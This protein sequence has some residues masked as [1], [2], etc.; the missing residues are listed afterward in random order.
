M[1]AVVPAPCDRGPVGIQGFHRNKCLSAFPWIVDSNVGSE[2]AQGVCI[3]K[4]FL[5]VETM[6]CAGHTIIGI[7]EWP[8]MQSKVVVGMSAVL[9]RQRREAR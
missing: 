8:Q 5:S 1:M 4:G 6:K 3:R 7:H 2:Q 9:G